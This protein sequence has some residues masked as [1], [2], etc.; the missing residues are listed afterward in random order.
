MN[1]EQSQKEPKLTPLDNAETPPEYQVNLDEIVSA[2]R[3]VKHNW[4]RR[5]I[6]ISCEGAGHPHHSHFL[7]K[8]H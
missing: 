7:T 8:K 3:Q 2:G 1:P 5:G 4:V 6:K